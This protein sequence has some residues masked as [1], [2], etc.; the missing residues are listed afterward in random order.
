MVF[1]VVM[2]RCEI[3]TIK[4]IE[5]QRIC[6]SILV[7]EK[8]LKSPL[9]SMEIKPV[10]PKWNQPWIY[11]GRTDAEAETSI[12]GYLL[13]RADS[14]EKTLMLGKTEGRRRRVGGREWYGYMASLTQWTWVWAKPKDRKAWC[15]AVHWVT[16]TVGHSLA[17]EQQQHLHT[18]FSSCFLLPSL[19]SFLL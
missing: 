3:W 4:K 15:A 12:F 13:W 7:M 9:D 6:F 16:K 14:L 5:H 11:I 8:T 18:A 10:Y 1:P 19:P 2:Y 17:A